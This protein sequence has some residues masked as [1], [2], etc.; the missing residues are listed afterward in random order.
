MGLVDL[1]VYKWQNLVE[2]SHNLPA[3]EEGMRR[4][5]RRL[6]YPS[7]KVLSL[8]S[9]LFRLC[10]DV[11]PM[12]ENKSFLEKARLGGILCGLHEDSIKALTRNNKSEAA[13][14]VDVLSYVKQNGAS[15]RRKLQ[16]GHR[17]QGHGASIGKL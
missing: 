1:S 8:L 13:A 3:T 2:P 17:L 12:E 14:E 15:P 7:S 9:F 4:R 10:H 5:K 16:N 6:H 11:T